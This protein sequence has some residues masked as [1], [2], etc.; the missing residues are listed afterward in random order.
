MQTVLKARAGNHCLHHHLEPK[1]KPQQQPFWYPLWVSEIEAVGKSG[2][3][4]DGIGRA[5]GR[6]QGYREKATT[7]DQ[8]RDG[9]GVR[10]KQLD[11]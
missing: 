4:G 1:R 7:Q 9:K 3:T 11:E 10:R 8:L 6:R 5:R 2:K